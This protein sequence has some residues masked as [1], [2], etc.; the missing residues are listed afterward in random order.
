MNNTAAKVLVLANPKSGVRWTLD[1]LQRAIAE[2]W[3]GRGHRVY[4]EFCHSVEDGL[5][6]AGRAVE[7]RTDIILVIGGDGTVSTVGR[8]VMG[9]DVKLG[10]IPVG[11]GNGFARHFNIPLD[12]RRAVAALADAP[13]QRIDVGT[14]N[15]RPFLVTCSMAW[16]ASLVRTFEKIPMRGVLPY[17]LAGVQEF[18]EYKAQGME[19]D[20]DGNET[21][22]LSDPL[23]C[24]V[25]NLTQYGGG[26][27]IAPQAR[28][29]DGS[30]ELVVA[31]KHDMPKLIANVGRFFDGSISRIP[32]VISR[33][34]RD[35][36]VRRE[37][38]APIQV[39][40][41]LED[42]PA[43]IEVHVEPAAL[44]VLVPESD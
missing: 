37:R 10:V 17:V 36:R 34:F 20:I 1:S 25:A 21:L 12:P 9:T 8:A 24:T 40:G 7:E 33:R 35:L 28:P 26:A 23:V 2:H 4:Y 16:D 41:E 13:A 38:E 30:L 39:D 15:G 42:A 31:L 22:K 32:E 29:D 43:D 14:V 44:N 6:K 27:R 3:E 19:F 11:S 18:F 5:A